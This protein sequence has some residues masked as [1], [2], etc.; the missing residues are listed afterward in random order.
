MNKIKIGITGQSGFIGY[1]LSCLLSRKQDMVEVIPFEDDYFLSHEKMQEFVSSCDSIVHL[2]AMNRGNDT[3]IYNTNVQLVQILIKALGEKSDIHVLHAS[4]IQESRDNAYGKSKKE[5]DRLFREWA[6]KK[7]GRYTALIIPNV[8]G[9]FGKQFYN[10]V[11]ATF[12]YQLTHDQNPE[13]H[14]D[15]DIPLIYV[16]DL[17][18]IIYNEIISNNQGKIKKV[19]V[20]ET[21][22]RRVSS[23]LN[24]LQ[25]YKKEY[26]LGDVI[27]ELKTDFDI[28]LFNTFRSYL[29]YSFF[30]RRLELRSDER[31]YLFEQVRSKSSGQSFFSLS[32]PGITRG[33]HYHTR[34]FER[35]CVVS[36][37][38]VIRFRKI[39]TKNIITYNV[40]GQNPSYVDIPIL[41]THNIENTGN[42]PLLTLFWSN[43]FFNKN[44]SDTFF[45]KV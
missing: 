29:D 45:E 28:A 25:E 14:I 18:E 4:S 12:C 20:K 24:Q 39:G 10:S 19:N 27:P 17:V 11:I 22:I 37:E 36:G 38:A 34:K 41:H 6:E 13:I 8:F 1:H 3:E 31:G 42:T 40:N 44:D 15:A 30:P 43:E 2:A 21:T 9:A 33:N 16:N 5:A 23:I 7:G 32:Y 26:V 35:F